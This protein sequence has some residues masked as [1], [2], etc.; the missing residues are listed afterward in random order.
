MQTRGLARCLY[1]EIG[2]KER[3][4]REP[5]VGPRAVGTDASPRTGCWSVLDT[6]AARHGDARIVAWAGA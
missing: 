4:T 6:M 1:V 5:V 2:G 3:V